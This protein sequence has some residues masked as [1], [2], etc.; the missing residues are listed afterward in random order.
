MGSREAGVSERRYFTVAEANALLPEVKRLLAELRK[1]VGGLDELRKK[2]KTV[3]DEV[4]KPASDTFVDRE[5]FLLLGLFH[6]CLGRFNDLGIEIKDVGKGLIDFPARAG[7]EEIRLCWLDG[8]DAVRFFHDLDSGFEGRKPIEE[9]GPM[10]L[11]PPDDEP[12]E[13]G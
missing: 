7:D 11:P 1:A 4:E 3:D 9:L 12:D 8:E 13:E 2:L 5:H 10:V 6:H